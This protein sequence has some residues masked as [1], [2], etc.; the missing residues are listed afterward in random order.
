MQIKGEIDNKVPGEKQRGP[1]VLKDEVVSLTNSKLK[2]QTLGIE[3]CSRFSIR[4][5]L[6]AFCRTIGVVR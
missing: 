6:T 1:V 2:D 4:I 5:S 3:V